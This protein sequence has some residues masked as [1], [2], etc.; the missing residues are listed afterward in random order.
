MIEPSA[1]RTIERR[2][3]LEL[4]QTT[5]PLLRLGPRFFNLAASPEQRLLAA[6]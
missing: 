4:R 1:I 3:V 6:S 2:E 5:L